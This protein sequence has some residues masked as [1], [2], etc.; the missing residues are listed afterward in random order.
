MDRHDGNP[1]VADNTLFFLMF[2]A[3]RGV[4]RSAERG[5]LPLFARTL[6]LSSD[7]YQ[8]MQA[9]YFPECALSDQLFQ[10][11]YALIQTSMPHD[12]PKVLDKILSLALDSDERPAKLWLAHAI[13]S[14]A[15]GEQVLWESMELANA[16]QLQGLL[17]E[18]FPGWSLTQCGVSSWQRSLLS[19]A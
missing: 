1:E 6:G 10:P 5:D 11:R 18:Y 2:R 13:A 9:H 17:A 7:Q 15:Y 12:F 4:I 14:A 8:A 3:I 16:L 19:C